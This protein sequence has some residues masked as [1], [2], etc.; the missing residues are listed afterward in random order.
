MSHREQGRTRMIQVTRM[1]QHQR[2]VR[3][4]VTQLFLEG[5]HA[6]LVLLTKDRDKLAV[7]FRDEIRADMFYVAELDGEIVGILA[8]SSN[9]RRALVAEKASL[10]RG[11]GLVR[12]T[13][14]YR[15]LRKDFNST[16]P[17]DDDTGYIEWVATSEKARGRGVSTAL[18]HSAMEQL[19]YTTF[20]LEVLDF[21]ENAFRL[22][23]KLGF[24][25]YDR[26]PAK[27]GEKR[28][29]TERIAMRRGAPGRIPGA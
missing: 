19:P 29:F 13:I 23:A 3:D 6:K 17:Y 14:A 28:V 1:D 5:F 16:L 15:A 10:R 27:G 8:V 4:E 22:Y 26:K 2:D 7:A 9:S 11:L 24:E 18:F 21:N 25:E 12:G 20:V